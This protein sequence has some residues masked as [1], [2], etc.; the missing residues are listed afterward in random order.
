MPDHPAKSRA[1]PQRVIELDA[2]R[3]VAV[4]G[5]VLINVYAFAL[6]AQAY[7]NPTVFGGEE[8]IDRLIWAVSFVFIEDKFR[9][10]F[11]MMFGAGCLILIERSQASPWR[12]HFARMAVLFVI[13]LV[14]S[15][16]LAGNDVL[17]AY[18]LAA[19]ALPFIAHL[20]SRALI[21][22]AI[23][24][25]GIHFGAGLVAFGSAVV[26]FYSGRVESDAFLFARRNFGDD[27]AALQFMLERGREGFEERVWRRVA[28]I[29]SQISLLTLSLPINLAA[30]TLGMALWKNRLLAAEWRTFRLQ[31]LAAVAALLSLPALFALVWWVADSDFA[32]SHVGAAALVLSAPFDAALAFAYA[33]LAMAFFNPQGALTRRFAAAGR[34]SLTNYLATSVILGSLFASWGLGLFGGVSRAQAFLIAGLPIAGM[35]L[36]S[37]LWI[38]RFG[39]GPAERLWRAASRV[40]GGA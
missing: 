37:P 34:L 8:W 26:D 25:V 7:Y 29:P 1:T 9:T 18:A 10:L 17:R 19:I 21:A 24:L 39:Q 30:M 38:M 40:L 15:V 12:A 11:A 33:A 36:L 23:G 20:S 14:H 4:A 22:V 35:L 6:P 27:P 31:R 5:I 32:G 16:L 3:G 28:G 13:G 2:L